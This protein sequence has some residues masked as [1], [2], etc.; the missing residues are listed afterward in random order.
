MNVRTVYELIN[1]VAPFDTQQEFDNSGLLVGYPAQEVS[2]ILFAL[3]VTQPVIDE[4]VALGA[5]LIVTHHPLMFSAIHSLTDETYE[6][7]LICRLVREGISLIS[8]HTN[9]DQAAGGINDT[10]AALSGLVEVTGDG[11]F[12]SG[13]LPAPMTVRDFADLLEE[14]L[15][16]TVRIMAPDDRIIRRVGLCSGSGGDEWIKAAE[17]GCDAF[18]SG[19]IKHHLALAMADAGIAALE[20]GHFATEEP[21]LAAL[22]EALQNSLNHVE[23]NVR[24][25]ISAVSA[26]S[27]PQQS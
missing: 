12:R 11:F 2:A 23:C 7:R 5:E 4:A 8:A 17:T 1:T 21:G 14:N 24:V 16:T 6:G 25:F 13:F 10:L 20:C 15:E 3:D 26:Y 9:L 27:F 19:E 18:V 22:A